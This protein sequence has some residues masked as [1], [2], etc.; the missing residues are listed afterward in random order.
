MKKA[1][2]FDEDDDEFGEKKGPAGPKK[3]KKFTE[4]ECPDC[5]ANNPYGDGFKV[6]DEVQCL[7]CTKLWRVKSGAAEDSFRLIEA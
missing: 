1:G 3:R 4:F 6:G 2:G 7:Y 5:M